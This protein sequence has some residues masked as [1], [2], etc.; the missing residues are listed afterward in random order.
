MKTWQYTLRE[1]VVIV[2]LVA[3]AMC[4]W[5]DHRANQRKLIELQVTMG[6]FRDRLETVRQLSESSK[7][8]DEISLLIYAV[9][10]PDIR[11]ATVADTGLRRL[12]G[13]SEG[14]GTIAS[15]SH[16]SRMTIMKGW[17]DWYLT[18][19][20]DKGDGSILLMRMLD[21]SGF[22]RCEPPDGSRTTYAWDYENQNT[23]VELP[24]G[25]RVT[26][27]YNAENRRVDRKP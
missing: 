4:W 7:N 17:V 15:G 21:L 13:I 3:V 22:P 19:G 16:Y 2:S 8:E 9:S 20:R 27:V 1:S 12:S 25:S 10:D 26:T 18:T 6:T 11:I 14:F 23:R 24:D 5:L